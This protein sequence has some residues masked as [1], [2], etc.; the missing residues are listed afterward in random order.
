[1]KQYYSP[2]K[3]FNAKAFKY[4]TSCLQSLGR[5]RYH[6]QVSPR[7]SLFLFTQGVHSLYPALCTICESLIPRRVSHIRPLPLEPDESCCHRLA[8]RHGP[9]RC[10]RLIRRHCFVSSSRRHKETRNPLSSCITN[11]VPQCA[12]KMWY[13]QEPRQLMVRGAISRAPMREPVMSSLISM[14]ALYTWR[15]LSSRCFLQRGAFTRWR[16]ID[17]HG[18]GH[19]KQLSWFG[20]FRLSG[21]SSLQLCTPSF[22]Y[23]QPPG[24][25]AFLGRE[26]TLAKCLQTLPLPRCFLGTVASQPWYQGLREIQHT[27]LHKVVEWA[28][29]KTSRALSSHLLLP[30]CSPL[31][32]MK[33]ICT[34]SPTAR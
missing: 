10:Q 32:R 20:S 15:I 11:S 31:N 34:T 26:L 9:V 4:K 25:L 13:F 7:I 17:I 23:T 19:M 33:S 5:Q 18:S 1:V 29:E 3:E 16:G 6:Q 8:C 30:T 21:L 14:R 24:T 27:S 22:I 2:S 28:I 12:T